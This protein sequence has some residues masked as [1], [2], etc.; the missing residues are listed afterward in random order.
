MSFENGGPDLSLRQEF[1]FFV[2]VESP[3]ETFWQSLMISNLN[4]F[5]F[6]CELF[7]FLPSIGFNLGF[8]QCATLQSKKWKVGIWKLGMWPRP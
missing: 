3:F 8:E 1:K 2:I 5:L 4:L 6:L 7:K